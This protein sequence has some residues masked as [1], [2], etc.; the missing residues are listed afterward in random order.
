MGQVEI[1]RQRQATDKVKA[2]ASKL[3]AALEMSQGQ[4]TTV[5]AE[6]V[7]LRQNLKVAHGRIQE[8]TVK[9]DYKN[10]T[11]P[12][13]FVRSFQ[14]KFEWRQVALS[15]GRGRLQRGGKWLY[16]KKNDKGDWQ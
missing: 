2:E 10:K 16:R 13:I 8:L 5:C 12:Q 15:E 4:H 3:K 14:A 9:L 6:N 1:T 7:K 11:T